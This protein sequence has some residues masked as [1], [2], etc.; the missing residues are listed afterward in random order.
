MLHGSL[1][2]PFV[3][4]DSEVDEALAASRIPVFPKQAKAN[5]REPL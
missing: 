3:K 1:R 2:R 4:L 5:R